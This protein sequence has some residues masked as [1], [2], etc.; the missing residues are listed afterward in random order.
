M[1]N[2]FDLSM[3]NNMRMR[4]SFFWY[5]H[6]PV[7]DTAK[8]YILICTCLHPFFKILM[9]QKVLYIFEVCWCKISQ[10]KNENQLLQTQIRGVS[11]T[12]AGRNS[13]LE[14]E[15]LKVVSFM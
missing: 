3:E 13:K 6:P 5:S 8:S 2:D 10:R 15:P 14:F 4:H 1:T 7:L 11:R 9:R 12:G